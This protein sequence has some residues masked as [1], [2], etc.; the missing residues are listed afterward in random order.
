MRLKVI[1][2]KDIKDVSFYIVRYGTGT[3]TAMVKMYPFQRRIPIPKSIQCREIKLADGKI[4]IVQ[5]KQHLLESLYIEG[6]KY[7]FIIKNYQIDTKTHLPYLVLEDKYGLT[8]RF[9]QPSAETRKMI[10]QQIDCFVT[11]IDN[12]ILHLRNSVI[13]K[14]K[15]EHDR[16]AYEKDNEQDLFDQLHNERSADA[17]TFKK[18]SYRG[19]WKSIIDKYPDSAHFIYELLQN[20]DDVE[21]SEV[22]VILDK[23]GI[24]FKHNG[25]IHFT[26]SQDD[27]KLE[28]Y[29]HINSIT[30]IGASTK[31][32]D[33]GTNK[34]GK[35]GVGFKSVFQYTKTP[36][37]FDDK[38]HFAIDDYIVPRKLSYDHPL[39]CEGETL[40]SLPFTNPEKSY[41]EIREKLMNLDYPILFL[42]HL[43]KIVWWDTTDELHHE[44]S[45]EI[46]QT[47]VSGHIKYELMT[48]NNCGFHQ[49]LWLFSKSIW[50][51]ESNAQHEIS[52]G[53]FLTNNDSNI[54]V[55][56][57][58]KI[59][60]FFPTSESFG[61]CC[62]C[63]APFLLTDSRQQ[64]KR[65]ETVNKFFVNE[66]AKLAAEA[67]PL[68][69][70]IGRESD[71]YLLN[72]NLF[73]IVPLKLESGSS[74]LISTNAF[75]QVFVETIKNNKI[76][77]SNSRD[78]LW[79]KDAFVPVRVEITEFIKKEQ[80]NDLLDDSN[81]DFVGTSSLAQNNLLRNYLTV[82]LGI[83]QFGTETLIK[84]LTSK[85]MEKQPKEWVLR[86]YSFLRDNAKN[87]YQK[88]SNAP[89][90]YLR[91]APIIKTMS[92]DWVAPYIKHEA[93]DAPNV[94]LPLENAKY[95]YNFIAQEYFDNK[96]AMS[97]FEALDIKQPEEG[98]YISSRILPKYTGN[99]E[100]DD[101]EVIADFEMIFLYWKNLSVDKQPSFIDTLREHSFLVAT[102]I[103]DL[104]E[105]F[106]KRAKDIYDD[107]PTTRNFFSRGKEEVY[108]FDYSFYDTLVQKYSKNVI[109]SFV[110]VLGAA[111]FPRIVP[112]EYKADKYTSYLD[113]SWLLPVQNVNVKEKGYV[114]N[115]TA[116]DITD[117][118]ILG[119]SDVLVNITKEQ[120]FVI[121]NALCECDI[122]SIK[123]MEFKYKYYSW[124]DIYGI[125]SNW[126]IKLREQAWLFSSDNEVLHCNAISAEEL[127]KVGYS[128]NKD[129]FNVLGI[130]FQHKSLKDLGATKEQQEIYNRGRLFDSDEEAEEARRLLEEKKR[131]AQKRK[132]LEQQKTD[133]PLRDDV[134]I[135][136][137]SEMFSNVSEP[138]N[139]N[140]N[141]K[142]EKTTEEKIEEIKQKQEE[143]TNEEI[144][145]EQ[146][147]EETRLLPQYT[148]KW[149]LN[150]FDLEYSSE[151]QD[152]EAVSGKAINI[153]F[154]RVEKEASSERIYVL[155]N[156]SR[157]IPLQLEE[158][159]GLE[160]RFVFSNRDELSVGFEVA[161]VRDYTLRVKAKAAEADGL[162][163]ID[164]KRCTR[165]I[166]S[167]NNPIALM[168]K[169]K[170][171]F[172]LLGFDDCFSLKDNLQN[173]VSFV[174]GPPGTGKTTHIAG[175]ITE[176]M[177]S[178]ED[179]KVLVLAPTNKACD[180]LTKK[181]MDT[182]DDA[183]W[184]AR[185]VATGDEAIEK[186]GHLVDRDS[187]IVYGRCCV[188]S[189]IARLPYDGFKD[190]KLSEVEWDYIF[191][192]EASMIPLGQIAY[193]IYRFEGR[194]II[195]S[196]DPLQIAPIVREQLWKDENIY[197]MVHLTTF[198]H[199][200]TEPINFDIT[201]LD[202]QYRSIPTIGELFS[203]Y[204]YNGLLKHYRNEESQKKLNLKC[205]DFSTINYF[206]FRVERYD[207]MF[208][209]KKLSGSPVHIY[210]VLLVVEFAK[211]LAYKYTEV[212]PD[213]E[214]LSIGIICPYKAE[215]QF[216]NRLL[217][218]T[219]DI[220]KQVNI[221]IGTIH[222]FQ[223]DECDAIIAVFNPPTGL[224]SATNQI[225][226][227][228]PNIINVAVSRARD[229][230]FV[231]L[232]HKDM[233]GYQKLREI[234]RLGTLSKGW[235]S[236]TCDQL[237]SIMFGRSQYIENASY[238]TSH[239]MANVYLPQADYRYEVRIDE[240]S[241]DIQ[242]GDMYD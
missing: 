217:E 119:L 195:I 44:Y 60:C 132:R 36:E 139:T 141:P 149:F 52:I 87:Y 106:L 235:K 170:D 28:N 126:L 70:K 86:L 204:A 109:S 193:A 144:K 113:L 74:D 179:L 236:W 25:R 157:T 140:T 216:I 2:I 194:P 57:R 64:L 108:L 95:D 15:T 164:W 131:K 215:A 111:K 230:L 169:L 158:I 45:K 13:C 105:S 93:G 146:L 232:P 210:S 1:D 66:L 19:V 94:Y 128:Y 207:S 110:Q 150:M 61:L 68:L 122:N 17:K 130:E 22:T 58:P 100:V 197:T 234:N 173:N 166:V 8:H 219:K 84:K 178:D 62:V 198:D 38:F 205:I 39:R 73:N 71:N 160:I 180:V 185:F 23:K 175:R 222:G 240:N 153:S 72:E 92:G 49:S 135:I 242:I 75:Y 99:C 182:N 63:H 138:A 221:T 14:I 163:E 228:N 59:F 203:D 124:Y 10:G 176:L 79:A 16:I 31:S 54:N 33:D 161:S 191:I 29:G 76:L 30:G 159:G 199:P 4:R 118:Q 206:P 129:L 127:L 6:K 218:Q 43:E 96:Q 147:L 168:T 174:F 98:D 77:F 50:V 21:A 208:G 40:F 227:N 155:R 20:A 156:P 27:L 42:R 120:S 24:V 190:W 212:H 223:G 41:R 69:C 51:E 162:N 102:N 103:Q 142:Q 201:F 152:L 32:F 226:L 171:A 117:Y 81:Y 82:S 67:L 143:E 165:A 214:R 172:R 97:F 237:E 189:T 209:P 3:G 229:Y 136:S 85:F 104:S 112:L 47:E 89:V 202:T 91:Y 154:G 37:I 177:N 35:F 11:S 188:V 53:Y 80:L 220:P 88:D 12:A 101:D 46:R 196:G 34:I 213:G 48:L 7:P 239:Q 5:D 55:E 125:P 90:K 9:Y 148:Y 186:A 123:E 107:L 115:P 26:I 233:D 184:L 241:V 145:R 187:E 78:Y 192:D 134:R 231:F 167:V 65:N 151:A 200:K 238:V 83:K 56:C 183:F 133:L 181:L 225:H 114:G 211:F 137:Q 18:D 121:W 116:F 224:K